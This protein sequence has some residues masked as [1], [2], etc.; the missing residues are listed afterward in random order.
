MPKTMFTTSDYKC[1]H[2]AILAQE[3][4]PLCE[5]ENLLMTLKPPYDLKCVNEV[6]TVLRRDA[7]YTCLG[8]VRDGALPSKVDI[9]PGVLLQTANTE[10]RLLT[11]GA[12]YKASRFTL[13]TGG[14]K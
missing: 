13:H 6:G 10:N 8:F 12:I 4:C 9:L 2:G 3:P 1:H 14:N 11:D 5:F 7:V